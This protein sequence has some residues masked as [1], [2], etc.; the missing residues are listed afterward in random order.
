MS[1]NTIQYHP[2][3]PKQCPSLLIS[4][5]RQQWAEFLESNSSASLKGPF[6]QSWA[7]KAKNGQKNAQ[8]HPILPLIAQTFYWG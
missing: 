2:I 4:N 1:S 8:H 3:L 6:G 7:V 5:L